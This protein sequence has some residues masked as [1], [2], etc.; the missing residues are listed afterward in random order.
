L[1]IAWN[2]ATTLAHLNR[3]L[4]SRQIGSRFTTLVY[5]VL[6]P[7]GIFT[8]CNGGH[9]YPIVLTRSG[10]RRISSTGPIL[11]AFSEATFEEKRVAIADGDILIMFSDGL[12]EACNTSGRELSDERLIASVSGCHN[13]AV[14]DVLKSIVACVQHHCDGA[15][16]EDDITLLV[17]RFRRST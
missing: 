6:S 10:V 8:C 5:G 4:L 11:G 3:L 9:N 15:P 12:V 2:P 14:S 7:D 13:Q 16:Q 17:T 1:Q